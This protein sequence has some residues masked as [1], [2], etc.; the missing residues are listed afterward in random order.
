MYIEKPSRQTKVNVKSRAVVKPIEDETRLIDTE[1]PS[2]ELQ[3]KITE[4]S[5]AVSGGRAFCRPSGT[6][7]VVRVYAEADDTDDADT[8][9]ANVAIAIHEMAEGTAEEP[10]KK[11]DWK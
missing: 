9:A 5:S 11:G 7:D 2:K 6:E 10:P 8:L 1:S 4:L 3:A